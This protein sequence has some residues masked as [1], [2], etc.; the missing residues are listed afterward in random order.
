[1]TVK[2]L[3]KMLLEFKFDDDVLVFDFANT[4]EPQPIQHVEYND[5]MHHVEI[6]I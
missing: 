3:I 2:E 6:Q 4:K 1:M 5:T